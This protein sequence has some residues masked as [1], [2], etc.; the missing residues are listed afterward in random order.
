[1]SKFIYCKS[2]ILPS[3]RPNL[4]INSKT[5]LCSV[6]S[7][8]N[9]KAKKVNWNLRKKEFLKIINKKKKKNSFY[10]C[11][12]PVSGGKD[13]TWQVITALKYKLNP[14]CITWRSPSRNEIGKK[15]LKNLI[16]LGVDHI[17]FTINP[18]IQKHFTLKTFKKYGNP[19]VAMH[20]A[21][22]AITVR[23]AIEK[24]IKLIL[25]G[26]NSA[27][28]YGGVNKLK[29]RFMT[30][31]WRKHYGLNYGKNIDYWFDK[32]L[33]KKNTLNYNLP[34]QRE[35]EKNK[36]KEIF[37]GEFFK[38]DPKKIFKI[39][40]KYGFKNL[41]KPKTGFYNFADIDDEFLITIHHFMKWYKFGF[42]RIWDNLS[43][44]IR[45]K[46]ITRLNALNIIKKKGNNLPI[47]EI[48]KFC[49]YVQI[50]K[51]EFFNICNKFRNK[52]IWFKNKNKN[53]EIKNF[54]I[55]NWKWSKTY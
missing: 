39:S 32:I 36:I 40:K 34:S 11:I 7:P 19:L 5:N 17:D 9:D 37:L 26:E 54:I 25:W 31:K 20:M 24:N 4:N 44:E 48:N 22:H 1:M 41:K 15:N 30:N 6:C 38:W 43:I 14:L 13:S 47:E 29:G 53:H 51:K 35:I 23:T 21:L 16:N 12:I 10:D 55:K 27:T 45:N 50:N 46:R 28:E 18:K 52:K 33:Q 42:T 3:T 8:L 2:C 49:K